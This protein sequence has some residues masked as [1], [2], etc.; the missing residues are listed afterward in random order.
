MREYLEDIPWKRVAIAVPIFLIVVGAL[1]YFFIA[2]GS[3][4]EEELPEAVRIEVTSEQ[5]QKI[6]P[7]V[8]GGLQSAGNFGYNTVKIIESNSFAEVIKTIKNSPDSVDPAMYRSREVAY[9]NLKDNF[10]AKDSPL[11]YS[12]S[13]AAS[14]TQMIEYG[15]TKRYFKTGSIKVSKPDYMRKMDW[16]GGMV[17]T[18]KVKVTFE[19]VAQTGQQT[20]HDTQWDGTYKIMERVFPNQEIEVQ[21]VKTQD[22]WKFYDIDM[23]DNKFLLST[24]KNP[25]E[26]VYATELNTGYEEVDILKVG[27]KLPENKESENEESETNDTPEGES[28]EQ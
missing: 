4:E 21:L 25:E 12:V 13:T 24:W 22:G 17:D 18:V 3:S 15:T 20:R 6:S 8:I 5:F 11:D 16:N 2:P 23:P 1:L 9:N 28:D 10:I 14:W 7:V 19:G 26:G 27:E